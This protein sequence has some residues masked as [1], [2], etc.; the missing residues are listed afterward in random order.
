MWL[1][2][3]G[4]FLAANSGG[5]FIFIFSREYRIGA[6]LGALVLCPFFYRYIARPSR[7]KPLAPRSPASVSR[8]LVL[9]S[10]RAAMAAAITVFAPLGWL[11]AAGRDVDAGRTANVD[12]GH[13]AARQRLQPGQ[14]LRPKWRDRVRRSCCVYLS[15]RTRSAP[16]PLRPTSPAKWQADGVWLPGSG[17]RHAVKI[18]V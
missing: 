5:H 13:F 9:F 17:C 1:V 11:L 6:G 7:Q 2:L 4:A 3:I 12:S 16:A 10:L 18:A 8:R 15:R 14:G